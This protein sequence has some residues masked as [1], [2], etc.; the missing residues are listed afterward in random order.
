M[1]HRTLVGIGAVMA[2]FGVLFTSQG[3]GYV[4]GSPMTGSNLWAIVG[5]VIVATG[6][7]LVVVGWRKRGD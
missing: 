1:K 6:L 3:L 7:C 2:L 4:H 5:P